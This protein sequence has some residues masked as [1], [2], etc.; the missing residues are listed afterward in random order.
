M[1]FS[2]SPG[3]EAYVAE[4]VRSGAFSSPSDVVADAL[5][6]KMRADDI[7]ELREKL[8]RSEE[9]MEA[10]RTVL[11]DDAFFERLRERVRTVAARA[12]REIVGEG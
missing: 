10:G 12:G 8:R 1:D 4:Q 2:L 7:A 3:L 6:P 11:A 9:D 5:C